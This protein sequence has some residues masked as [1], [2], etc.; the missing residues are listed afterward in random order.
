[1]DMCEEIVQPLADIDLGQFAAS[2]KGIDDG[3]VLGCIM[4]ATEQGVL[5]KHSPLI[6]KTDNNNKRVT[7]TL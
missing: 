6:N 2:H 4:V 5:K 3:C 1:M 7:I